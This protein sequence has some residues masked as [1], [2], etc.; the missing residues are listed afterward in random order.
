LKPPTS[1]LLNASFD[2]AMLIFPRVDFTPLAGPSP[3]KTWPVHV[4]L[5]PSYSGLSQALDVNSGCLKCHDEKSL[6]VEVIWGIKL[7]A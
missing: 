3:F 1:Q 2:I 5:G 6:I 4:D 7:P